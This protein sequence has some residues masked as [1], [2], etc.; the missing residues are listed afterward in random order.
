[1]AAPH[2]ATGGGRG[3]RFCLSLV[4]ALSIEGKVM[5]PGDAGDSVVN[6]VTFETTVAQD[7]PMLHPGKD[8]LN[9]GANLLV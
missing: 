1:M 8:M 2:A 4:V 6:A 9:A 5:Q 7:L 3:R